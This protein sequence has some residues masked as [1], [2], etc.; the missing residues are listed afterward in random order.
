MYRAPRV[1]PSWILAED[2]WNIKALNPKDGTI[3]WQ[4]SAGSAP[5][6][7]GWVVHGPQGPILSEGA[8][9]LW[10]IRLLD[11][12]GNTHY[13]FLLQCD[14]S[15]AVIVDTQLWIMSTGAPEHCLLRCF[16]AEGELVGSCPIPPGGKGLKAD[17]KTLFFAIKLTEAAGLYQF[18]TQRQQLERFFSGA[19]DSVQAADG[20]LLL[21]LGGGV[22]VML[23]REGRRLWQ[24][25]N[26]GLL[27]RF[28][29]DVVCS[30]RREGVWR[31]TCFER[32]SGKILWERERE[33]ANQ[34]VRM[35][36]VGSYVGIYNNSNVEMVDGA[37]GAFVQT[38]TCPG[39]AF[40]GVDPNGVGDGMLVLAEQNTAHCFGVS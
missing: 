7:I 25:D 24:I 36:P 16:S 19:V 17:G 27:P 13:S 33:R 3:G 30:H 26:L 6:Q 9:G 10:R 4:F 1:G 23:D 31:P 38:L 14:A 2:T 18:D 28:G 20:L 29:A 5:R 37:T 34:Y 8:D 39:A 21:A 35:L 11:N 12:T 40:S 22:A 32:A 15:E